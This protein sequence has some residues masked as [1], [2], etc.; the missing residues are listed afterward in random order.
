[1]YLEHID[2]FELAIRDNSFI[3]ILENFGQEYFQGVFFE[4]WLMKSFTRNPESDH[5]TIPCFGMIDIE[6]SVRAYVDI[7]FRWYQEISWYPRCKIYRRTC[8]CR[9]VYNVSV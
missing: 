5:L 1:M 6:N 8:T 3:E 7:A 9:L 4:L 2:Y